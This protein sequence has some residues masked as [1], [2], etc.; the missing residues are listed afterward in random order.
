MNNLEQYFQNFHEGIIGNNQ[1]FT[2]PYGEKRI[3]YAD[4]TASDRLY[5]PIEDKIIY[6]FGPFVAN[7]KY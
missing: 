2:T 4:W 5:Q 1:T 7:Q 6:Q 3:C